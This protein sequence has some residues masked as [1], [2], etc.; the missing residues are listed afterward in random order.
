[1]TA[2]APSD[3]VFADQIRDRLHDREWRMDNL[4]WIKDKHGRAIKFV[5]NES[6]REF[7]K[8]MWFLNLILKDRQRGFSTLIAMFIMDS[9]LFAS[10]TSAGIIDITMDDGKKKLAKIS[11]AYENLPESLQVAV[12]LTTDNKE[13]LEWANGSSVSVG[14][15]HRG[16]TMQILHISEMGKIAVRFPDRA[17]EIR[18]GAMNTV[19]P[20]CFVFNESTAEG[21]SGEF[22]EDCQ[23]S[24]ELQDRGDILTPLDYRFHFFGWWQGTENEI[25]PDGVYIS[26]EHEKYFAKLEA[27]IGM[28]LSPSKRAWYAKKEAQQKDDMKREFPGTPDEAF[29]AAIEGTYLA[30]I[31]TELEKAGQITTFLPDYSSPINTGWDFGISDHMTIWLHQRVGLQDRLVGYI[32]G[33]DDDVLY[34]WRELNQKYPNAIWGRHFLPHDAG[35]RRIG[36][37]TDPALPPK[38]IEEILKA[39]GMRDTT[40]VPRIDDKWT[41]IQQ[42]KLWLPK[43]YINREACDAGIKCL[44]N[45][46]REWDD[47]N[48][49]WKNRPR[50]DWAMHGYDGLESLIRGIEAYGLAVG[51]PQYIKPLPAE[52]W[53]TV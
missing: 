9:C 6:Q 5:R 11:F 27:K 24:R 29:E 30:A 46:R 53:R 16:G 49:C 8:A 45:F 48:G 12:P 50:H 40:I 18:T 38:T 13:T 7:W 51:T 21:N 14:T 22:Y 2:A 32:S 33:A 20:G 23:T 47:V 4:Y 52:D 35:A 42:V 44:K 25:D 31:I 37:S 36:T 34:Y 26:A 10:H 28:T 15:S 43:A 3:K 19:A 1:M 17:R 41:A 39:A